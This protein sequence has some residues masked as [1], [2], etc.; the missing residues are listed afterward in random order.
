MLYEVITGEISLRDW[1]E[2]LFDELALVAELLDKAYGRIQ[3]QLT[4]QQH[5]AMLRDPSL[6][7]SARLLD[8]LLA[9][10]LDNGVLGRQLADRYGQQ[11]LEEPLRFWD[12]EYFAEEAEA[13]LAKQADIEAA[14]H[15][16]FDDFLSH[17]LA[18]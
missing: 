18:R 12:E 7:L 10:E 6:T 15:L 9:G 16:G 1:G 14:D 5:R 2:Q 11:L 8:T 13:S 17:Y 3:Y 4:L